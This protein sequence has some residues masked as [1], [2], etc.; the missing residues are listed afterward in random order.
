MSRESSLSLFEA[1]INQEMDLL[2]DAAE[3]IILQRAAEALISDHTQGTL[4]ELDEVSR[5]TLS[6]LDGLA[7]KRYFPYTL[8]HTNAASD[9]EVLC[10]EVRL[11]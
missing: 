7:P 9:V 1:F 5:V 2:M 3:E 11:R 6:I 4:P 10:V 8:P